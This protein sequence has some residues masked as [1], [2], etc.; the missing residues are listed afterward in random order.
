[1]INP[2]TILAIGT[3]IVSIYAFQNR[4]M[5]NKLILSP[6]LVVHKKQWYRVITHAFIHANWMHLLFNLIALWSFGMAVVQYFSFVT[7]Y[8]KLCFYL[9]YFIGIIVASVADLVKQKDNFSYLSLGA[10]GGVSAV[11][12]SAIFF[13]PWSTVLIF[14]IPCPGIVFGVLYLWYSSYMSK[15]SGDNINHGAHFYGAVFGFLYPLMINPFS[16]SIFIDQLMH[17]SFL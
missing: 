5:T 2:A 14:F 9:L 17:P 7:S 10:S 12:F 1:M 16:I 3:A 15:K 8:P 13:N 4:E 6:Y 11:I